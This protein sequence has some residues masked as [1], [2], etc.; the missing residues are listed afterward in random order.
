MSLFPYEEMV[1]INRE[2]TTVI[3]LVFMGIFKILL[4]NMFIAI[5]SAHYFEY[6]RESV[7]ESSDEEEAGIIELIISIVR[8]K[9]NSKDDDDDLKS[10]DGD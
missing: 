3:F 6:Q 4:Y 10:E 9:L 1:A 8:N 7:S 2:F 5:I